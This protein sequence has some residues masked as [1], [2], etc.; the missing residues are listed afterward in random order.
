MLEGPLHV[1]AL[2]R[3]LVNEHLDW[4]TTMEISL[5]F[6]KAL[7]EHRAI[8]TDGSRIYRRD[9]EWDK[10]LQSIHQMYCTKD[11]ASHTG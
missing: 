11:C 7:T 8:T 1:T 4:Q 9:E 2:L 3:A 6:D 5:K 10:Q